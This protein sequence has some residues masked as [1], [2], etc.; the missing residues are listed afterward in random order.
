MHR[1]IFLSAKYTIPKS[2]QGFK[3]GYFINKLTSKS[4]GNSLTVIRISVLHITFGDGTHGGVM[5]VT[6]ACYF[7]V[8]LRSYVKVSCLALPTIVSHIV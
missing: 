5:S 7:V 4:E 3:R 8:K 2:C 6:E 1:S